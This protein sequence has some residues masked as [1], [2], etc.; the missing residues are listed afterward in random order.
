MM[1]KLL[2]AGVKVPP[3]VFGNEYKGLS[4]FVQ[5]DQVVY[6][7][8]S[9]GREVRLLSA[10]YLTRN[11]KG[12]SYEP[13]MLQRF[14]SGAGVRAYVVGGE[15]VG[16]VLITQSKGYVYNRFDAT[17]ISPMELP[18]DVKRMCV[19][20]SKA[21]EMQ[22]CSLDLIRDSGGEHYVIDCNDRAAFAAV[23]EKTGL[24]ISK[25]LAELLIRVGK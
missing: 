7:P 9:G 17:N 21:V 20:A 8:L 12:L 14:V 23:E 16:A 1:H 22:F 11:R 6:K 3:L 24:P 18:E 25:K 19:T 2:Q 4:D 10:G 15:V 13:I 5:E